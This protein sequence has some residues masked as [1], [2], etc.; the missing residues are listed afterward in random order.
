MENSSGKFITD[1]AN[2]HLK[3]ME[4]ETNHVPAASASPKHRQQ[5]TRAFSANGV[6]KAERT[7]KRPSPL[8]SPLGSHT[9]PSR[10][11]IRQSVADLTM[12][13]APAPTPPP[14][15]F[16]SSALSEAESKTVTELLSVLRENS[17]AYNYHV[18]LVNLLHKGFRAHLDSSE[19]ADPRKYTLLSEMRQA[20]EAMDSRFAVGEDIWHDWL[21]DEALLAS[22]TEERMTVTELFQKAVQDEPVSTKLWAAY[23]EWMESNY[24]TCFDLEGS[25]QRGWDAESKADCKELFTKD[26]LRT[27]FEQATAATKWRIDESHLLWSR[28]AA[29]VMAD[30]PAK[31]TADDLERLRIF[32]VQ[33]LQV[34][35]ADSAGTEQAYFSAISKIPSLDWEVVMA[36]AQQLSEPAKREMALREQDEFALQKAMQTGDSTVIHA[37]FDAF[38][39]AEK[40]RKPRGPFYHDLRCAAYDRALL[41]FPTETAWWLDYVDYALTSPG[42][43]SLSLMPLIER[44]T[45]HCP[46]SGDLWSRR[47]LRADVERRSRDEIEAIKHRATNSGLL[48]LGGMEEMVKMLQQWCSYL[49]RHAFSRV[50]LEDARDTAE[51][52]IMSALEDITQA[53]KRI[54]GEDFQGDPLFR[55]E[56]VQIKFYTESRR[57]DEARAKYESLAEQPLYAR[58]YDFWNKYYNWELYSWGLEVGNEKHRVETRANG[59]RRATAVV[60]KALSQRD[61]DLPASVLE[62]YLY[63]FQQHES[64]DNLQQGLVESREFTLRLARQAE[65]AERAAREAAEQQARLQAAEVAAAAQAGTPTSVGEKRK[66]EDEEVGMTNGSGEHHKKSKVGQQDGTEDQGKRDREHN[67]VTVTNLPTDVT[68][69]ELHDFFH[70]FGAIL[71][72]HILPAESKEEGDAT[73]SAT[74]EFESHEDAASASIRDGK[75]LRGQEVRIHHSGQ[76]VLYACNY[77][78]EYDEA[79]IRGLFKHYGEIVSVRFP[80]L[81]LNARRRFCYVTFLTA[82]QARAASAAMDGKKLDGLHTLTAQLSDPAAAKRK[83]RSGPQHEG[84]EVIV[85]NLDRKASEE[86]IRAFFAPY[87]ELESVHLLKNVSGQLTGTGFFVYATAEQARAA[88]DAA[89]L[90]PFRERVLNVQ[91]SSPK[92]QAPPLER[93]HRQDIIVKQQSRNTPDASDDKNAARRGSDV[94][95]TSSHNPGPAGEE[96]YK[97]V[98]ERKI[99]VFDLPDTVHDARV[100]ATLEKFGPIVKIQMR[101]DIRGAIVEF[102]DV[103]AAFNVR[104]GVDVS[105]LGDGVRTGDVGE[106]LERKKKKT[107]GIKEEEGDAAAEKKKKSNPLAMVPTSVVHRPGALGAGGSGR[108]GGLGVKRGGSHAVAGEGSAAASGSAS[109]ATDGAARSNADFRRLFTESAA[110]AGAGNGQASTTDESKPC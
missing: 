100:R 63:H 88:V 78:A 34:P 53:G 109:N 1:G 6:R 68:E 41:R 45:R 72:V 73:A 98:R 4:M 8:P 95:M 24:R 92:G 49:R 30:F 46:G 82:D 107:A 15:T 36:H 18:E 99:A 67:T 16:S 5:A 38:I 81:N 83:P 21:S 14:R 56:Q 89:H 74:V 94:S 85:K 9:P 64:A 87:G 105:A 51:F 97:T 3:M 93:M 84:R 20:R 65:K 50:N 80:S 33:R 26:A 57:A 59:P 12:A 52:G 35:H 44:A 13:D 55:L 32:F 96:S 70:G 17:Y 11:G 22:S 90:K 7:E 42:A 48:D 19:G 91:I 47:I 77:P 43:D 110:G 76:N 66:R 108:R 69:K 75:P 25:N 71:A 37:A 31:P 61:L 62:L 54:Y 103:K 104:Q 60:Q 10:G 86:E 101:R 27:V 58:S 106:L 39:K 29:L 23:A 102:A 2:F 40:F 79:T 28:Y